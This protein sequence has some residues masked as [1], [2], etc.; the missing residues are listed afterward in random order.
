MQRRGLRG[1]HEG[2]ALIC[3][4]WCPVRAGAAWGFALSAGREDPVRTQLVGGHLP[5]GPG[6]PN[7]PARALGLQPS[8]LREILSIV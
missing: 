8:E 4:D 7:R 5:E 6:G 1:V 2:G 3:W